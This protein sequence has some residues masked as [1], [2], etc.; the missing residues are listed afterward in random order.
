V[1]QILLRL[2]A[3]RGIERVVLAPAS[4]Q[5]ALEHGAKPRVLPAFDGP[6][7]DVRA[8]RERLVA[9]LPRCAQADFGRR[10]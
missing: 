8:Q 4:F 6:A 1:I 7:V 5:D 3:R 2:Q 9:G 10:V